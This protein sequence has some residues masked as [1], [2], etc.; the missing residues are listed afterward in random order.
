MTL[1]VIRFD[2]LAGCVEVDAGGV[3]HSIVVPKQGGRYI[4]PEALL[5]YIHL[6]VTPAPVIEIEG[7]AE[8]HALCEQ[9]SPELSSYREL[10]KA[11]YPDIGEYMDAVVKGDGDAIERYRQQCLEVKAMYP[12]PEPVLVSDEVLASR[13]EL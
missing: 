1:K 8:I 12:K 2:A 9:R 7:A 6:M 11:S 3:M 4:S 5:Q 13:R 10:R